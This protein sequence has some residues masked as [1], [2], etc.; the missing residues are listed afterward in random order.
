MGQIGHAAQF[1]PSALPGGQGGN[2]NFQRGFRRVQIGPGR[3]LP[4]PEHV[5][6]RQIPRGKARGIAG[7]IQFLQRGGAGFLSLIGVQPGAQHQGGQR[8]PGIVVKIQGF[9]NGQAFFLRVQAEG[10]GVAVQ[11]LR[12]RGGRFPRRGAAQ[13]KEE[14]RPGQQRENQRGKQRPLSRPCHYTPLCP[15]FPA[16]PFPAKPPPYN[17]TPKALFPAFLLYPSQKI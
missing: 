6:E 9:G 16:L 1:K 5:V 2:G 12:R 14:Q 8:I 17:N 7:I 11:A 3:P 13:Q 10:E 15:H 4:V